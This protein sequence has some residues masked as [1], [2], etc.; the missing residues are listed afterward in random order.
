[1]IKIPLN[2]NFKMLIAIFRF[3]TKYFLRNF[4]YLLYSVKKN[5]KIILPARTIFDIISITKG[6]YLSNLHLNNNFISIKC[7]NQQCLRNNAPYKSQKLINNDKPKNNVV[8]LKIQ[9]F[10][11]TVINLKIKFSILDFIET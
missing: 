7:A 2:K 3:A 10:G 8:S 9:F 5:P 11:N 6:E 4:Y 1:M